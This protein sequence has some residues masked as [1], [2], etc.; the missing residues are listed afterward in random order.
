MLP[1]QLSQ[2][3]S[4][5]ALLQNHGKIESQRLAAQ[6][7]A[8]PARAADAGA[9]A[10]ANDGPFQ[11]RNGAQDNGDGSSQSSLRIDSLAKTDEL[12]AQFME[13]VKQADEVG[14]GTRQA[15][16]GPDSENVELAAAG[17]GQEAIERGT[18]GPRPT[19]AVIRVFANDHQA[20]LLGQG[21]EVLQLTFG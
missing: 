16:K 5:P 1:G 7:T 6:A 14:D 10:F 21:T 19:D 2:R 18:A 20:T 12:D 11:L 4:L 9:D 17:V 13:F 8:L 15:V 3:G